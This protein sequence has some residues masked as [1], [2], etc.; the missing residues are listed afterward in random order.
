VANTNG[1]TSPWAHHQHD[2]HHSA[3][4]LAVSAG[5]NVKAVQRM[6]GHAKASMTGGGAAA[7]FHV[8]YDIAM[9]LK[10]RR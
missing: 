10:L 6:L 3:A 8:I 2:L 7:H 4:S 5:A 9:T 1:A